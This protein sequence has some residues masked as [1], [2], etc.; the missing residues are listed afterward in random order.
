MSTTQFLRVAWIFDPI[1]LLLCT[2]ALVAYVA[3]PWTKPL[4]AWR[5]TAFVVALLMLCIALLSP[6]GVLADGVLFSAHMTQHLLLL[7]IVPALALMSLPTPLPKNDSPPRLAPKPWFTWL[8]GVGAMW[9]AFWWPI[10]S[11][12]IAQR[13]KPL[14]GTIYLF[15]ACTA[16]T[17]LG[18]VVTFSPIEI[19]SAYS[20][21][22]NAFG[23]LTLVR[24]Q[25]G[26]SC[27]DDQKIGGL[28]MWVPACVIYG[29]AILGLLARWYGEETRAVHDHPTTRGAAA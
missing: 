13:M 9:M 20:H 11:P 8:L 24:D 29:G 2:F 17:V 5:L 4:R 26:L 3:G 27:A 1:V 16:C 19:C 28:L 7:L 12:N 22:T 23:A 18:I 15:A 6:I 10:L 25:W 14:S 21:P